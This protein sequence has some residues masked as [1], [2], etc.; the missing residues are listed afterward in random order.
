[1]Q[2]IQTRFLLISIS[3]CGFL[4]GC[5]GDDKPTATKPRTVSEYLHD[6]DAARAR[7]HRS[8]VDGAKAM[9]E[10]DVLNASA[11]HAK[12]QYPEFLACWPVK[13]VNTANTDHACL[14]K[15]G[16]VR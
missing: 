3:V 15:K 12:S 2:R 13:P 8:E 9:Q 4:S 14:D 7:I 1:M 16:F 10:E 11:A 6:I 5:F